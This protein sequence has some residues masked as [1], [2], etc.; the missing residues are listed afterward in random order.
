MQ[1]KK[2]RICKE[3]KTLTN[4]YLRSGL[5]VFRSH[6]IMTKIIYNENN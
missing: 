6:P 2:K 4:A 1:N 3:R 5:M